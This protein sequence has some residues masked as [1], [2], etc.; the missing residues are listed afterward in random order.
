M[1]WREVLFLALIGGILLGLV[2]A[3]ADVQSRKSSALLP[4]FVVTCLY[5][6]GTSVQ[7]NVLLDRAP[8]E[9]FQTTVLEKRYTRGSEVRR[10]PR[11]TW[12]L[13]LAAWGPIAE[14]RDVSVRSDLYEQVN[15]G[16]RVCIILHKGLLGLDWWAGLNRC[17]ETTK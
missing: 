10:R 7:L 2:I 16:D 12:K 15:V 17:T 14:A 6:Y 4:M 5:V 11:P 8:P 9:S 13:K 1:G 3:W